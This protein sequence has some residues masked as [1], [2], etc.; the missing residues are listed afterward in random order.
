MAGWKPV[1]AST[2]TSEAATLQTLEAGAPDLVTE[3]VETE[4]DVGF[5]SHYQ[6]YIA[7][8]RDEVFLVP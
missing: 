7:R 5:N 2:A 3:P 8:K 1:S 6:K 4:A